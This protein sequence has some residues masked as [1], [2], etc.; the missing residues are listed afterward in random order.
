MSDRARRDWPA[1]VR[2]PL[3]ELTPPGSAGRGR[4]ALTRL[5]SASVGY[6]TAIGAA[7]GVF[8]LGLAC[9]PLGLVAIP[10]V[11]F[12]GYLAAIFGAAVGLP[13]G[14]FLGTV[15]TAIAAK[16][17]RPLRHPSELQRHIWLVLLV[18]AALILTAATALLAN[19]GPPDPVTQSRPRVGPAPGTIA[20][21]LLSVGPLPAATIALMLML[22]SAGRR[23]VVVYARAYG[24]T[25]GRGPGGE[26]SDSRRVTAPSR[27]KAFR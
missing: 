1:F 5:F 8:T 19:I 7:M 24:W 21:Y 12:Y 9:L 2:G 16:K 3:P 15:I 14:A 26:H 11:L 25:L 4:A 10:A 23:L 22:R 27:V 6:G 13:C 18:G 20:A 17:H